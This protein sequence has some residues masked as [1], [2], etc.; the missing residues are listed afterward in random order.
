VRVSDLDIPAG[1]V[2][3]SQ[4]KDFVVDVQIDP[5]V[6][7]AVAIQLTSVNPRKVHFRC[8]ALFAKVAPVA[9]PVITT[10][11][12][13]AVNGVLDVA[14]I[15]APSD[16]LP[17][18][19]D[20]YGKWLFHGPLFQGISAILS[21]EITEV[22]GTVSGCPPKKCVTTADASEWLVDPVLLDSSMQLAGIW[23][24]HFEDVTV[25]PTGFKTMHVFHTLGQGKATA[26]VFLDEANATNL[27]CDLA[28]YDE[29]GRLALLV[30]GL[31]GIA[32]K[33][34]NRFS[35]AAPVPEIA[36]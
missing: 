25:L 10:A 6:E 17:L 15:P 20:V 5:I 26:R 34:F 12:S 16:D 30:E 32:S 22:L 19:E 36:R 21:L 13:T 35:S 23:A 28:I 2:F 24:R 18:P 33:A 29:A 1:I 9:P 3:Q 27:L 14:S 7:G 11:L 4:R 8:Q 31:G